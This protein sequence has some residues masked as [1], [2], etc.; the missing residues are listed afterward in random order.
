[1]MLATLLSFTSTGL[2]AEFFVA[3]DGKADATG[4]RES[5]WDITSTFAGQQPVKPGDTVWLWEGTYRCR[6]AYE[7]KGQGYR[8]T[9]S[10][11][12]DKPIIIRAAAGARAT[13]DGGMV[14]QGDHLWIWDLEVAQPDDLPRVTDES[15]SHPDLGN[16]YG[17]ITIHGDG[18]R[19]INLV[20]QN[21]LG[22][23]V[24][25]WSSA[26]GGEVYGCII[27]RNGWKG[28]DRNHGHC[29]YTQNRDGTKTISNCMMTTR[30]PGGHYTMHAYGSSRAYVDSYVIEDNVAWR[31]GTFLV[32]GGRPSRD[33]VVRRNY[34]YRMPL[35]IG[36]NAPHNEN[37]RILG[38]V[39]FR[40][41]MSVNRYQAGAVR[42]NLIVDGGLGVNGE[43]K[44]ENEGNVVLRDE[45]PEQARVVLLPNRYDAKRANLAV[46]N[47]QKQAT[48]NVPTGGFLKKGDR[49]HLVDPLDY[50][51][52]PA[53]EGKCD[54]GSFTLP[55]DVEF[56]VFVVLK[57]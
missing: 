51:G 43:G 56:G 7:T 38:N 1:M 33:I 14:I 2:A 47:W 48:V 10:G 28:P 32:G 45:M 36:Y 5:P 3:P 18:C 19:C 15:G 21:N 27:V 6:E 24:G 46:F 39:V 37:C 11:T 12:T 35:Q 17:G 50:Y 22:N 49:F 16:P 13:I 55:M 9:L 26:V 20:V 54:E 25:W 23:G 53:Y 30:W 57:D 40:S 8:V 52:K 42:D 44:V 34:L 29:I 41:G 31:H 4:T